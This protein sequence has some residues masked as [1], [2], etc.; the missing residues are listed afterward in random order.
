MANINSSITD[1]QLWIETNE[2]NACWICGKQTHQIKNVVLSHER[3]TGFKGRSIESAI[4]YIRIPVFIC[5]NCR[6]EEEVSTQIVSQIMMITGGTI[7]TIT[8]VTS[9]FLLDKELWTIPVG[10][11]LGFIWGLILGFIIAKVY[12]YFR[13]RKFL[14]GKKSIKDHP[15]I[16]QAYNNGYRL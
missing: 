16:R 6:K 14:I 2:Q 8:A 9:F 12:Q 4:S 7:A 3:L 11:V 13:R 10:A 15:A 1:N 5:D